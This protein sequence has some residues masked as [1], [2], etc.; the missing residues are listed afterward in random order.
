MIRILNKFGASLNSINATTRITP[1][2]NTL[3]DHVKERPEWQLPLRSFLYAPYISKTYSLNEPDI[4]ILSYA[5]VL[6][7]SM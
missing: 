1:I 4:M 5:R 7:N 3:K 2:A 6:K